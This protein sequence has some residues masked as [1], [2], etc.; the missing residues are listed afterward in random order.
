[1]AVRRL[2]WPALRQL[3]REVEVVALVS[4]SY[5]KAKAFADE[6][7]IGRVYKGYRDLLSDGS[8]DAVLIAVPIHL[9]GTVLLGALRAGKHVVA[10]KPIAATI[11]QA[12]S[13]LDE[14][15]GRRQVL[16]IGENFRYNRS[17][18][19]AR[20]L[21]DSGAI[22][23]AFTF[24][25]RV[26]FDISVKA[27]RPWISRG[28]RHDA[29]HPGGFILDAGVHPVAAL[30]E[31]LGEVSEISAHL[32]D[33][34]SLINGPDSLLM[35]VRMKNDAA[36]QCF[37]CYTSKETKENA[38]DFTVY[39]T[40]GVLHIRRTTISIAHGV[41]EPRQ[42]IEAGDHGTGEYVRQWKNFCAAIHGKEEIVSTAALACGDL[43]VIDAA[44]RSAATGKTCF[45]EDDFDA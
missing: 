16:L 3:R 22:G 5:A 24:E 35:Q 21:I 34:S 12:R 8:V 10:E 29:Q 28:W 39:G 37:F 32:L 11:V 26:N 14:I 30:R 27:R 6:M 38:L 2:H 9:N 33:T 23:R 44:L 36:G 31:V 4:R 25:L 43:A 1:M 13:I 42:V 40:K 45:V 17:L 7:K 15:S 19:K 20:R 18:A 41:G